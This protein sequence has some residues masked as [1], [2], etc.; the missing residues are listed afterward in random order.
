MITAI[1]I[2]DEPKAIEVIKFHTSKMENL[3]LIAH[4][5]Q[6]KEAIAFLKQNPVDLIFLDINMPNMSG[7][8]MLGALRL[9]PNV[10]FTTAYADFALESYSYDAIDY[11]LKPFEFDRFQIAVQKAEERISF[12]KNQNP[13]FF[14]KDGFKN[15]KIQF[16]EILYIK[17]SG[18][19][20]DI[21]LKE[22]MYSPRMTFIELIEKLPSSEFV[23]IHQSY[24]VNVNTIDKI[25]NNHVY[26]E[27]HE[28]P[29]S[30]SYRE[31]FF[32]RLNL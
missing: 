12:Q 25:E 5:Y 19:Y 16:D 31:L 6:P 1:A 30:G 32:K 11:L 18:N 20:L 8:E 9:K 4:F 3:D 2:D 27:K 28:I 21:V 17:G 14:I 22:K 13:F 23:R 7:L 29:I 24:I 26:L 15:I 10:I